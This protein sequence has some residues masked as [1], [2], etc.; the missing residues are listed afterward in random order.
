MTQKNRKAPRRKDSAHNASEI[1]A[2]AIKGVKPPAHIHLRPIDMPYWQ[3][4]T[5]A[6]AEWT[7]IDLIFAVNLA[8]CLADI[9]QNQADY[10]AEGE[11]IFNDRGT[12]IANPRLQVL[13]NLT[14][15]AKTL[16][17]HLKV[18]ATATIGE[19]KLHRGK[20]TAKRNAKDAISN[21]DSLIN[22]PNGS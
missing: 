9:E 22:Q 21:T 12:Q 8:R 10:Y 18:H 16:A 4:I 17:S 14:S 3:A 13:S 15:R 19:S 1:M 6:R 11:I 5:D 2:Q 7:D 20:N